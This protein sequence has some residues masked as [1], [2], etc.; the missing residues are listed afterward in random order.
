MLHIPDIIG[1]LTLSVK[2]EGS[3]QRA[4]LSHSTSDRRVVVTIF[5]GVDASMSCFLWSQWKSLGSGV[6]QDAYQWYGL[7]R[8]TSVYVCVCV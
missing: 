8:S 1:P 6:T 4:P 3:I 7:S 2:F 5:L